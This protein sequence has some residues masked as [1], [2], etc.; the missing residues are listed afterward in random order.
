MKRV[1]IA[2]L[3]LGL[4]LAAARSLEAVLEA[5]KQPYAPGEQT[6]SS[7]QEQPGLTPYP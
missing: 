7:T 2:V 3:L 1:L 4:L 6:L 5:V